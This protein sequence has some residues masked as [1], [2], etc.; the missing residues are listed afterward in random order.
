MQKIINGNEI[1]LGV[2]YYP[3]HWQES[4]WEPDLKRMKEHGIK[5]VRIAEFSWT[6]VEPQEG[7]YTF[8]LFDES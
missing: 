2:C 8:D 5:T 3:E 7:V 4:D 1:S 6:L